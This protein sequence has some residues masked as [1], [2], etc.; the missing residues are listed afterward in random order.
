MNNVTLIGNLTRDPEL[1]HTQTG[2]IV[3]NCSM[4]TN[5]FYK[6]KQGEKQ[7]LVEYHNLIIWQ[8]PA[9]TFCQYLFKGSKVAIEGKLKTEKWTDNNNVVRYKTNIVV[10]NFE[11]LSPK[12]EGA[13]NNNNVDQGSSQENGDQGPPPPEP[14]EEDL[15]VENIPF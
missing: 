6:N 11:F 15:K 12:K 2:V 7:Q 14:G 8:K 10:S 9:E 3:G 4:A 1:R 13:E 5:E